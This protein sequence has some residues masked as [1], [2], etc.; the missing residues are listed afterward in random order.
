MTTNPADALLHVFRTFLGIPPDTSTPPVCGAVLTAAYNG[1]HAP[2]CP[3][4]ERILAAATGR[5]LAAEYAL[6][7]EVDAPATRSAE[8]AA[9]IDPDLAR[10]LVPF[11]LVA[12]VARRRTV[13]PRLF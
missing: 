8:P 6:E 9:A 2:H 5:P 4:C 11:A 10:E 13:Q 3:A 12:E 7:A 1:R